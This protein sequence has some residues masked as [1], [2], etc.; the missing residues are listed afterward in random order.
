M[1]YKEV[2][3][4]YRTPVEHAVHI[5]GSPWDMNKI[6]ELI[7]SPFLEMPPLRRQTNRYKYNQYD[8]MGLIAHIEYKLKNNKLVK[9][10]ISTPFEYSPLDN[11][12][13]PDEGIL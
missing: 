12:H 10:Y 1:E 2:N 4:Y 5:I 3:E 7:S 13:F 9:Q 11:N 6:I 8:Q